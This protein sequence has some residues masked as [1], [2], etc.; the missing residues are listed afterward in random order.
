MPSLRLIL[1]WHQHQPF[2]KNL[3]TGEYRLPWVRLHAL[4]DYYG[5]VKLLDEFPSVHQN[6]N[7]V[8]S[9]MTQIQDYVDGTAQDPFLQV[10]EKPA[11]D[12]SQEERRFALQYLFQANP[13]NLI[14][15]YPRYRELFERFREHGADPEKAE[16]FFQAQDFTDLQVLSQIAW[17]D[18]FFLEEKDVAALIAKGHHYSLDDQKFVMAR[19]RE[20]LGKV[21]PVHAEAAKKGSIEISATPFYHPILPLVCD[22]NVGAVSSPGLPL[23]QNRFRHPEDAR[24]QLSRALDYQEKVFGVRPKGVW[25]SEGSVSEEVLAIGA[26]LGVRWMATDE[27]VLGRS[28]NTFFSRDGNG[29][30]PGHLGETLYNIHR[31]EN[32]PTAMH[33]VF[34][35]HTISDLIGFVYSGMPPADAARHLINNVKDAARPVLAKGRDAVVSII[36][37]G[38]NAWEYYP[39]SGREFLRRFYD[40]LQREAGLEAV[41]VSEAIDRHKDFGRMTSLVPGSWINA[42]FNVWIGAPEDN[43]AWDYLGNSREFYA[44]NAARASEAQRKLAFEEILIAE[45]SDWNWWYGPEHHSANDR[46]FD[47]LY[48]THLSNVYQALGAAP[49]DYLSQP[50]TGVEVRPAFVRQTA[51]IHPRVTGDKVKYFEWMGAAAYTADHR[52]GS[53]HGKQFLLDAVYAGIDATHLYGRLDFKDKIPDADFQIVVNVESWAA[54]EPRPRRALR[55]EASAQERRMKEWKI[56]NGEPGRTLASSAGVEES[57]KLALQRN[58]EFKLPLTWLLATPPDSGGEKDRKVAGIPTTSKIRLRFSLWQNRLPVDSLPLEGW[59]ELQV[60]SEGELLFGS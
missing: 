25:P 60:V 24:E 5:M 53:M 7:L 2:Y 29:R 51:Y 3:V 12:L 4:K 48:R 8:P 43:R 46:D 41:T 35:D 37:D 21:L 28:T 52:S 47:E 26:S 30:L 1:L 15:R 32:G 54:G 44:Q 40:G 18:E 19:E 34:R 50:I 13:Q 55:V 14:G 36:L 11:K 39:K 56:E 22:T 27:G 17:F 16:R 10:A 59:I 57:A 31:Y 45:G 33:L 20:L 6:F 23:P 38:E 42:N 9:L 58:F 49:P